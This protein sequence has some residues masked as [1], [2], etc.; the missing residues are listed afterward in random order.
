MNNPI[1]IIEPNRS[2]TFYSSIYPSLLRTGV[3]ADGSCFYHALCHSLFQEYR[4]LSDMDR[5][6]YVK[7]I[8][9]KLIHELTLKQ[10]KELCQGESYRM[11]FVLNLRQIIKNI[12]NPYSFEHWDNIVLTKI[13]TEW[14][15]TCLDNLLNIIT[16]IIPNFTDKINSVVHLTEKMTFEQ[17]KKYI[18]TEWVDEL[19]MELI[20]NHFKCNFYFFYSENRLPYYTS[21]VHPSHRRN[22]IFLSIK[23]KHY[24]SI[25]ELYNK[26]N[27]KRVFTNRDKLILAI[28]KHINI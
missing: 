15:T 8:R 24:E 16:P 10:F 14:K 21:I 25:G 17:F 20:S 27:V 23:N 12:S 26:N 2:R 5:R 3:I 13:S 28:T 11:Q 19:G 7:K 18:Q 6:K 22:I 4:D 9:M 1:Y